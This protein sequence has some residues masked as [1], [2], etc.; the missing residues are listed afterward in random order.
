MYNY[1]IPKNKMNLKN[2]QIMTKCD[3]HVR[4]SGEA[5]LFNEQHKAAWS[6]MWDKADNKCL[7]V[8]AK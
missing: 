5:P 7:N 3:A 8:V 4:A 6:F 2:G 1:E